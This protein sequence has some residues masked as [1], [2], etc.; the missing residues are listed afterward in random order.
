MRKLLPVLLSLLLVSCSALGGGNPAE[1]VVTPTIKSEMIVETEVQINLVNWTAWTQLMRIESCTTD[2]TVVSLQ[3]E[4]LTFT[5]D[6]GYMVD[7]DT[8]FDLN[9]GVLAACM[10]QK[11]GGIQNG[12]T[13]TQSIGM[14]YAYV[15]K[16]TGVEYATYSQDVTA[17]G[18]AIPEEMYNTLFLGVSLD[19][20]VSTVAKPM[21]IPSQP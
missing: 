2:I 1:G 11:I 14:V 20:P 19:L 16:A 6:K 17:Y 15:A 10:A 13:I 9:L 8:T 12:E 7:G 18:N 4:P 5:L 3:E 21:Q